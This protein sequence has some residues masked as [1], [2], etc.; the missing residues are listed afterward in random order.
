MIVVV[1]SFGVESHEND[2]FFN[3]NFHR[4]SP[5]MH[6]FSLPEV[7]LKKGYYDYPKK[8]TIKELGK[9]F[10][11]SPSTIGE[12]LQRGKKKIMREYFH[13]RV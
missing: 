11:V 6:F 4:F 5:V 13:S 10:D 8:I 2:F 7:A 3:T 1:K 9:M 12:T